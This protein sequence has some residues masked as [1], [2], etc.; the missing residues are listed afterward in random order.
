MPSVTVVGSLNI[1]LVVRVAH[2]P[3]SGETTLGW[4]YQAIPGGKGANQAVAAAR[5]GGVVQMVGRIG[6]DPYG[7]TLRA[8]L[9]AEAIQV[10]FV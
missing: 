6:Q 3:A 10:E 4:D 9:A 5:L 8:N 7:Q 2:L 1:D